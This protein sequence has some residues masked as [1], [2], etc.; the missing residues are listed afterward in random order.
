MGK[1][2]LGNA[3]NR[4][5]L[6]LDGAMGTLLRHTHL[7]EKDFRCR[8]FTDSQVQQHKYCYDILS[9]TRPE[10]IR[11]IH[12]D[13]LEAGADI[14]ETNTFNANSISLAEFGLSDHARE[15]CI[16]GVAVAREAVDTYC[17]RHDIS[18]AARPF[19]AGTMGP[20]AVS[21]SLSMHQEKPETDFGTLVA[22]YTEQAAALL[23]AG[24]DIILLETICDTL[25]ADTA[26]YGIRRAMKALRKDVPL[27]LSV[28][29][30][31]Q[32]RLLSGETLDEFIKATSRSGAMIIGLNCGSGTSHLI[33]WLE[34]LSEITGCYTSFYPS[35]G[36]PDSTGSYN[37]TPETMR[38]EIERILRKRLV[39]IIGGCCGT[40]PEHIR[41]IAAEA[42]KTQPRFAGAGL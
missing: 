5:V 21:L 8:Q 18:P 17:S 3:L 41:R 14:I 30:D 36:L 42:R 35:A 29:L 25:N 20:T 27:M 11:K 23:E 31:N 24:A 34:H 9:I 26:I 7:E 37:E 22:A 39:N 19:I 2:R 10:L 28:T 40:T 16:A 4:R 12:T 6:V 1:E 15:I 38:H 13:Y 33:P 32:G